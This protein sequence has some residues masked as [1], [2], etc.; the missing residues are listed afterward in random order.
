MKIPLPYLFLLVVFACNS[1]TEIKPLTGDFAQ[2]NEKDKMAIS[3]VEA[4]C[5]DSPIAFVLIESQGQMEKFLDK[6]VLNISEC[7][8]AKKGQFDFDHYSVLYSGVGIGGNQ[9]SKIN[10][11]FKDGTFTVVQ[12]ILTPENVDYS[13]NTILEYFLIEKKY[14]QKPLVLI[15]CYKKM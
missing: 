3:T 1:Q 2:W 13:L 9:Q 4:G 15:A 10:F 11:Y 7:R 8:E 12:T 6:H 5:L 14:L